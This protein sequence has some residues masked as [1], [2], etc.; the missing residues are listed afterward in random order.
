MY[1]EDMHKTFKFNQHIL[2][3]NPAGRILILK[4]RE[5]DVWMFPGGRM[6]EEK[7]NS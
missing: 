4:S 2:I 6:E 7:Q 5:G 1:N 3:K